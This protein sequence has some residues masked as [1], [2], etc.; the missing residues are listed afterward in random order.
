MGPCQKWQARE[1]SLEQDLKV[2]S[3]FQTFFMYDVDNR[4]SIALALGTVKAAKVGT[5]LPKLSV[6][7]PGLS[8]A[9]EAVELCPEGSI[10]VT[11]KFREA[12]GCS[13]RE[14]KAKHHLTACGFGEAKS[15]ETM[16][17]K[18]QP[19]LFSVP[20]EITSNDYFSQF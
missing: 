16:K 1:V 6:F 10:L 13:F 11:R 3:V 7:G 18:M 12:L 2:Q 17:N 8:E 14:W 5:K 15:V 20:F 19:I 4:F 9:E